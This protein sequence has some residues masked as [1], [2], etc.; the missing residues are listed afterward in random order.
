MGDSPSWASSAE[1]RFYKSQKHPDNILLDVGDV[2]KSRYFTAV[3]AK[4]GDYDNN[5][6]KY[7]AVITENAGAQGKSLDDFIGKL[8]DNEAGSQKHITKMF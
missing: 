4:I 8:L 3:I 5:P 7:F 6:E 2:V 1:Y